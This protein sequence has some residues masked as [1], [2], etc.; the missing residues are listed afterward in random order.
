[1]W[2]TM[3][4]FL[5]GIPL[6]LLL[7]L[8]H[9]RRSAGQGPTQDQ[10]TTAPAKPGRFRP[11][12][13]DPLGAGVSTF[14]ETNSVL[15]ECCARWA[16][17]SEIELPGQKLWFSFDATA[18][19]TYVLATDLTTGSSSLTDTVMTLVEMDGFTVI[20]ESD[21]DERASGRLASYIEWTCPA[22]GTY[23]VMVEPYGRERGTFTLSV[24]TASA[25]SHTDPCN[26][27]ADTSTHITCHCLC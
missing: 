11:R 2:A 22:T 20:T 7:L 25:A 17:R 26:V 1:M 3:L 18:G 10:A 13:V 16:R 9:P 14:I 15:F 24:N 4:P 8:L 5:R 27:R 23:Y 12:F 6:F 19:L 21:D